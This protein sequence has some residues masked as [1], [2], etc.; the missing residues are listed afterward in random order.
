MNF[1]DRDLSLQHISQS[2]QGV[3]QTHGRYVLDGLGNTVIDLGAATGSG[4]IP[5]SVLRS[6]QTSSM[7]VASASL[8][9]TAL[10]AEFAV[11]ASNALVADVATIAETALT[12]SYLFG[13]IE[14]ASYSAYAVSASHAE[15]YLKKTGDTATGDIVGTD[16]IKTRGGTITRNGSGEVTQVAYTGGR[17]L[18]IGRV[19]G[20]ISTI[21]DGA[22]TWTYTRDVDNNI[23]SWNV[24]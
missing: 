4:A 9:G 16:F 11:T 10:V 19:G 23:V 17:T 6:E 13:S 20:Y 14:S 24:T 2:Y 12:A 3:L 22:R 15:G 8:A 21:T 5:V 7:L 1:P 18:N